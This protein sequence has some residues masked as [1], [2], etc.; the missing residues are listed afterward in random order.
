MENKIQVYHFHNGGE[1]GVLSVI[2]NLLRF[3]KNINIE[4]HIIHVINNS[5]ISNYN[6]EYTEGVSSEQVFNHNNSNNNYYTYKQLAKLLPNEDAII[7]AHDFLELG[8]ISNLGLQNRVIH[9]LHG[10]YNYYYEL[11]ILH[12]NSIDKFVAIAND[13]SINLQSLIPSR[14]SDIFYFRFPV[15][16]VKNKNKNNIIKNIIFIGRL[17]EGKGYHLLPKIDR[18][19]REKKIIV[20][21]HIVGENKYDNTCDLSWDKES[22]VFFYGKMLNNNVLELLENM[23]Y[24]ILPSLSEGLPVSLVESMKAGVIPFVNDIKGG[25]QE[26]VVN[27]I[28]GFKIPKNNAMLFADSIATLTTDEKLALS[29]SNNCIHWA[30]KYF[31]P[32]IN[33]ILIEDCIIQTFLL[34]KKI[35][36]KKKIYTSR[37]D[38]IWLPNTITKLLRNS[39]CYLKDN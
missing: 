39:I 15:P 20:N 30:N 7:I 6:F 24:Y 37:L 36:N 38:K 28:T 9:F 1:G 17:E 29:I 2:K 25:I 21:W 14:I 4:N 16:F 22:F 23:D 26:V 11:A 8:M 5:K 31:D 27:G 10:D 32:Y 34:Q 33:T 18:L 3:S 12:Q 35:K 19:L 13:I